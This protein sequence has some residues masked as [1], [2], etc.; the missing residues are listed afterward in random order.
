M[1]KHYCKNIGSPEYT[2][3]RKPGM[4]C[5]NFIRSSGRALKAR[6]DY[7]LMWRSAEAFHVHTFKSEHKEY[8]GVEYV[9][10]KVTLHEITNYCTKVEGIQI[11]VRADTMTFVGDTYIGHDEDG[12]LDDAFDRAIDVAIG[13]A[14]LG[15]TE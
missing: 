15:R 12:K 9:F 11:I 1:S 2:K 13:K 5:A 6:C 10:A 3:E 7:C 4:K 14:L 8:D